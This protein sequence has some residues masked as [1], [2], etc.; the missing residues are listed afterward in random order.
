MS[1]FALARESI[2][3]I[4]DYDVAVS[5]FSNG[6]EERRLLSNFKLLGF[7]IKTPALTKTQMQAY[8]N[9]LIDKYGALTSF[10]FTSPFDDTEYT[11]RFEPGSF[12]SVF[13]GGYFECSFEFQRVQA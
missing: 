5:Q 2:E 10:T 3:E 13:A 4:L 6:W 1:D 11:V 12:K 7:K 9:F 8:R